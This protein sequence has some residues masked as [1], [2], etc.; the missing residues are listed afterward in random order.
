MRQLIEICGTVNISLCLSAAGVSPS[1][2]LRVAEGE[3]RGRTSSSSRNLRPAAC[4][5]EGGASDRC[6]LLALVTGLTEKCNVKNDLMTTGEGTGASSQMQINPAGCSTMQL[7]SSSEQAS[8]PTRHGVY[9]D[10]AP[11]S[12][13]QVMVQ[14]SPLAG[15]PPPSRPRGYSNFPLRQ[16]WTIQPASGSSGAPDS[17]CVC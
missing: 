15:Q 4:H 12:T 1:K 3:E 13:S 16:M 11:A 8:I 2:A 10:K 9:G 5:R 17:A 6:R 7:L 14:E